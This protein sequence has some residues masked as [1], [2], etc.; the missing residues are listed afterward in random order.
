MKKT[1]IAL[2]GTALASS[3]S[4]M[5]QSTT[6]DGAECFNGTPERW[7]DDNDGNISVDVA[8]SNG[9]EKFDGTFE[10]DYT[11]TAPTQVIGSPDSIDFTFDPGATTVSLPGLVVP[12]TFTGE[13]SKEELVLCHTCYDFTFEFTDALDAERFVVKLIDDLSGSEIDPKGGGAADDRTY[14]GVSDRSTFV[15]TDRDGKPVEAKSTSLTVSISNI[16]ACYCPVPEP[17]T[18]SLGILAFAALTLRR[19]R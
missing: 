9:T 19:K 1:I 3:A 13:D 14:E 7:N 8:F 18:A 6:P 4:L 10:I 2:I 5:A 11:G 15:I 17:S 12:D 16:Q